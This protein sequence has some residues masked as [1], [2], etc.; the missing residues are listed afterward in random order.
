MTVI[1]QRD[2][3]D[4]ELAFFQA[5]GGNITHGEAI[6]HG[7]C[8]ENN[9]NLLKLEHGKDGFLG[10]E[11][12]ST[13]M[14]Y[15]GLVSNEAVISWFA[16]PA[17]A[18]VAVDQA[19]SAKSGDAGIKEPVTITKGIDGDSPTQILGSGG[20]STVA[21]QSDVSPCSMVCTRI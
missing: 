12:V 10:Q 17:L 6:T 11:H 4:K 15:E 16:Q 3:D 20:D 14:S 1:D 21:K 13:H 9:M 19:T 8:R 2:G 18:K 7:E 5:D